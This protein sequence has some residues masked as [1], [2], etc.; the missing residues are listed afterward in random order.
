MIKILKAIYAILTDSTAITAIIGNKIFP[1]IVP[2]MDSSD[3][4][5]EYPLIILKRISLESSQT[6][7][8][9][10]NND[11]STIE[12]LCYATSY[13]Q[14]VD[15]A[16]EVRNTLEF[17]KGTIENINISNSRLSG[18]NEDYADGAYYQQLTFNIN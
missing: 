16:Q 7:C 6:K 13:E 3:V 8:K 10:Q 18:I 12:V 5:I 15:L 4:N 17:Y 11:K 2:D 14:A 1:N 9:T